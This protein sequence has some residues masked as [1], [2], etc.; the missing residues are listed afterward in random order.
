[1][2][3]SMVKCNKSWYGSN[4]LGYLIILFYYVKNLATACTAGLDTVILNEKNIKLRNN[5]MFLCLI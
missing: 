2:S 3:R 1:M 5:L 4:L